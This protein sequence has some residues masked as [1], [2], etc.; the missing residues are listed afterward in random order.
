MKYHQHITTLPLER[1]IDCLVDGNLQALVIEGEVPNDVLNEAWEA[2][3]HQY[4]ETLGD[5]EQRL[6]LTMFKEVNHLTITLNQIYLLCDVL[7]KV[8]VKQFATQLNSLTGKSFPFN[9]QDEASYEADIK[10]SLDAS[11]K[12]R[13]RLDMKLIAFNK[14]QQKIEAKGGDKP[15]REYFL[16]M[17]NVLEEHF[18]TKMEE[19]MTVYRY[20]DR[21]KR[22][23][24]TIEKQ[25]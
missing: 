15:T 4:A 25:N 21:L 12:Y 20:A 10:K 7:S 8:Y 13:V 22:M 17:L 6:Y 2:I 11:M 9:V 23:S 1:F 14:L 16:S 5:G 24:R 18:K 3:Q 19:S